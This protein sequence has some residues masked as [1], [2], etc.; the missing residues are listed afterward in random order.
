MKKILIALLGI[1]MVFALAACGNTQQQQ[2]PETPS[3]EMS[4]EVVGGWE[5]PEGDMVF[6]ENE[7]PNAV[8]AFEKA[9]AELVGAE[10]EALAVLGKQVVSGT[11]FAYL[12][13]SKVVAPESKYTYQSCT[14]IRIFRGTQKLSVS[15]NCF[16]QQKTDR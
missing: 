7:H 5:I 13:R 16:R 4:T 10:H 11:N 8:A 14:F 3:A 15:K 1:T 9:T 2:Q 6:S 12:C